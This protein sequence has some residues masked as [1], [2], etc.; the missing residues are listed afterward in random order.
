MS[1]RHG[2]PGSGAFVSRRNLLRRAA[3]ATAV[4]GLPGVAA[5]AAWAQSTKAAFRI[6]STNDASGLERVNG[7]AL[8]EG[9]RAAFE[10]VNRGGGL[11]GRRLE[12]ARMDDQFKPG[13][14]AENA[15]RLANDPSILA[16][17]QPQGTQAC[18]AVIDA[19]KDLAIVGPNTGTPA[20]REKPSEVT[21][22]VR[23][24]FHHEIRK[25]VETALAQGVKRIGAVASRDPLG[26]ATLKGLERAV[27][28]L[29]APQPVIAYTPGTASPEV[30][31]AALELARIDPQLVLVFVGGTAPAFV[32]EFREAGGTSTV[33]GLS[34]ASSQAVIDKMGTHARGFGFAMVVPSP[35][36]LHHGIVRDYQRDMAALDA[37]HLSM[38]GLE[39]Y[40]NAR[41]LIEGM[42]RAPG[43]AVT[44]ESLLAGLRRIDALDLGGFRLSYAESRRGSHFVDVGVVGEGGR[45][46]G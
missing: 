6:G 18:M 30:K 5:T 26:E 14:A 44:R 29:G 45:I 39:G 42:R 23:A 25:L 19:V 36:Q 24:D 7:D 31:P 22:F 1:H 28:A 37:P 17:L 38:P 34:I 2:A 10:M 35:F 21:F 46:L 15:R 16:L 32:H 20:V 3:A 27:Q 40:I 12:I 9:A 43:G 8:H 33:Y 11:A 4:L 13:P 41:V